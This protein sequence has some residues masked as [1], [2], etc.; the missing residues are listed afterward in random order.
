[1]IT[2]IRSRK[3]L[4]YEV[5]GSDNSSAFS[6]T[7][8]CGKKRFEQSSLSCVTDEETMTIMSELGCRI[9]GTPLLTIP[10]GNK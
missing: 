2:G 9:P 4:L 5:L 6:E 3:S 7:N 1:M 8:C 10:Q